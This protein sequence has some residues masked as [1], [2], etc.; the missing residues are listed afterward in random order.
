MKLAAALILAAS[1]AG[2]DTLN[3][4][5][6]TVTLQATERP[7]A[8]AEMVFDNRAVNSQ[9]DEHD[10]SLTLG[11]FTLPLNFD[12]NV[13]GDEDA[14]TVAPPEGIVCLPTS[15]I[16]QLQEGTSETLWLFSGVGVGM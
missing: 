13:L 6:S 4:S 16:L 1:A 12:W 2:A 7:G 8:L 3:L 15:C 11:D 14:V 10:Y 9:A 5:G